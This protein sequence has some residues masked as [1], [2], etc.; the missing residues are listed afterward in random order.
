MYQ[1][2]I[3]KEMNDFYIKLEYER[4]NIDYATMVKLVNTTD[5]KSVASELAGSSP[6]GRTTYSMYNHGGENDE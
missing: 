4:G 5:L 6:A 1:P 2:P 3:T